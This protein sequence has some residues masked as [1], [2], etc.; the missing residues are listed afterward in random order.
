M[1]S[2]VSRR[3][4]STGVPPVSALGKAAVENHHNNHDIKSAT[5]PS[6]AAATRQSSLVTGSRR[7][8][9]ATTTTT[10]TNG[11]SVIKAAKAAYEQKLQAHV[12]GA[13]AVTA[14]QNVHLSV[15]GGETEEALV[16][17][18]GVESDERTGREE[19]VSQEEG[20]LKDGPEV[21]LGGSC[22]PTTWR[23]D[24][25]MPTLNKLG[26]SFYNPQVSDWTPD[27][28]ELEHRAKEKARVL[29]FVMD[30]E[31]RAT[32]GAIEAAH[33]AGLNTKQLVLVLHPYKMNQ[34]ILNETVSKQ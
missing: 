34:K 15:S 13:G 23:A 31:T 25:A 29:F 27:L 22:N 8:G 7:E 17:L 21:F 1:P 20:L 16:R 19:E 33:I 32:A 4:C 18:N 26:I 9:E 3:T 12:Q 11:Q 14:K 24:V 30:S 2:L 5:D 10:A 6:A 28:I